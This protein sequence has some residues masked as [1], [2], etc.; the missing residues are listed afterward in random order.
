VTLQGTPAASVV[1]GT[2]YSFTPTVTPTTPAVTFSIA[3]PPTWANF[4]PSTGA[5]TGTPTASD[6]GATA[7]ITITAANGTTSASLGPFTITV[8]APP[9]TPPPTLGSATLSWTAPTQN[10]D[11]TPLT[12]L[13]G[14][15]IYYGTTSGQLTQAIMLNATGSTT[16]VVTGLASGTYYF[17]VAA[18]ASDGTESAQSDVGSKTI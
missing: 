2:A 10:T 5:L 14:Y 15:K 4:D 9:A 6:V 17:A 13:A 12:D 3:N 1:A 8:T 16:Y 18:L 11:G 7:N